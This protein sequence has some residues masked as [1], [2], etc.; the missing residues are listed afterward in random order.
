MVAV[1]AIVAFAAAFAVGRAGRDDGAPQRPATGPVPVAAEAPV[2]RVSSLPSAGALP[3]LRR[4]PKP[5]PE[6]TAPQPAETS[7]PQQTTTSPTTTSPSPP[8]TTTPPPSTG[9]GGG[10]GGSSPPL[11]GGGSG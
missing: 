7:V 4:R 10:G 6:A 3:G 1:A 5:E 9:G 11:G 8:A 2:V